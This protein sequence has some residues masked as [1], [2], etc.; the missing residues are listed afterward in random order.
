MTLDPDLIFI[1]RKVTARLSNCYLSG[2]GQNR[3]KYDRATDEQ[4]DR[5]MDKEAGR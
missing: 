4:T 2:T 1:I 3:G 5:W